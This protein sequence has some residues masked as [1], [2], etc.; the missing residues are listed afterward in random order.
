MVCGTFKVSKVPA[1]KRL[2][3]EDLF[4]A[5]QP[6]PRSVSSVPA[7]DGTFTVVAEFDPCPGDTEHDPG[8]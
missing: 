1:N 7:A 5:N 2:M 4:R 3:T 6:P 8:T